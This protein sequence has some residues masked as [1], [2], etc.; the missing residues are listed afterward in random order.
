[1]VHFLCG[2]KC[3]LIWTK[4]GWLHFGRFF[5]KLN[6]SPWQQ[7]AQRQPIK[8]HFKLVCENFFK[9]DHSYVNF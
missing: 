6:W 2:K 7:A 3:A 4:P 8:M 5:C 1:M 9:Q